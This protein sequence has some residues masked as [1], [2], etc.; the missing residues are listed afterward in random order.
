[1]GLRDRDEFLH[2]TYNLLVFGNRDTGDSS[3]NNPLLYRDDSVR[4][5]FALY[6]K[7]PLFKIARGEARRIFMGSGTTGNGAY[8]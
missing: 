3:D 4:S 7:N 1:V 5:N 6:L 8:E 2:E